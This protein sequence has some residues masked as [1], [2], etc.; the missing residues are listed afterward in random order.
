MEKDVEDSCSSLDKILLKRCVRTSVERYKS[1]IKITHDRKLLKLGID[2]QLKPFDPDKVI[3]NFSCVHLPSRIKVLL[4]FGLDFCLPVSKINFFK[5][6]LSFEKLYNQVRDR[7]CVNFDNFKRELKTLCSKYFY[8][9]KPNKIFSAVV[10]KQD[11]S[12]L[13]NFST[14]KSIVVTRPDKG[15]GV[16]I[17]NKSDYINS[18]TSLISNPSKFIEITDPIH[19]YSLKIEDKINNFLRKMK[20]FKYLVI[21]SISNCMSVALALEFSMAFL[22]FTN[23]IL[24]LNF[25]LDLFLPPTIPLVLI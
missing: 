5:Y 18:M 8:N 23:L 20:N 21:Q 9:F 3:Y 14:N 13:K 1:S 24:I 4:A 22:K 6:F 12:L 11:I 17:V 16:V 2:A 7:D 25:N 10:T 15:R 19:K